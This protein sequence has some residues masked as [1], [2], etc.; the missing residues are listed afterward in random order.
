MKPTV[1]A[2]LEKHSQYHS[3]IKL[4]LQH[5]STHSAVSGVGSMQPDTCHNEH[6]P[7]L[8]RY[9]WGERWCCPR[10]ISPL[11]LKQEFLFRLFTKVDRNCSGPKSLNSG[12]PRGIFLSSSKTNSSIQPYAYSALFNIWKQKIIAAKNSTTGD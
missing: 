3:N 5:L 8:V 9:V 7:H 11:C 12:V 6:R 2:S 10:S 1:C 4:I